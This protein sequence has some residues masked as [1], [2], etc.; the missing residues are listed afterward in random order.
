MIT[1]C[2]VGI[3]L[4]LAKLTYDIVEYNRMSRKLKETLERCFETIKE[5]ENEEQIKGNS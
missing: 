2:V 5:I 4:C 1:L 3:T